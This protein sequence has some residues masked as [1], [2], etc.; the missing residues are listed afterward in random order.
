MCILHLAGWNHCSRRCGRR[1]A[2]RIDLLLNCLSL[3]LSNSLL[4]VPA[5]VAPLQRLC[6]G[7][8]NLLLCY[9]DARARLWDIKTREFWRS[10]SVEKA[11][12]LLSQ[13]GWSQW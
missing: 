12:E 5:S 6:L 8:D 11:D 2:V 3:T 1:T 7:E 4:V 13:G 9:A 10:M